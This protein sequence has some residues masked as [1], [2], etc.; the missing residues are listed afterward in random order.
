M[1][2]ITSPRGLFFQPRAR[3][4]SSV[5]S[6]RWAKA[7]ATATAKPL[8][9]LE[10]LKARAGKQVAADAIGAL[11]AKA[12][13]LE[14]APGRFGRVSRAAS[15]DSL[16]RSNGD[17]AALLDVVEAADAMP[18]PAVVSAVEGSLKTVTGLL[19][20]WKE[21]R[22]RDV[23]ALNRQLEEAKLPPVDLSPERH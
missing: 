17:L 1:R 6:D 11:D 10:R 4:A 14:G 22:T 23:P 18:T 12:G 16:A 20:R 2:F 21:I 9:R 19:A 8:Q 3:L 5:K 7:G 15:E 13:A